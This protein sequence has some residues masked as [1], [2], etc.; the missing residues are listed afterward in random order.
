[1]ES[2]DVAM[3]EL[4]RSRTQAF[5]I[6]KSHLTEDVILIQYCSDLTAKIIKLK[7]K[8]VFTMQQM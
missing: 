2:G 6:S 1:M 4:N 3:Q 8:G 5:R 7:E